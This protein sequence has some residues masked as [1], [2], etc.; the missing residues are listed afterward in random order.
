MAEKW[1]EQQNSRDI[2]SGTLRRIKNSFVNYIY[3][4]LGDIPFS[5]LK[6]KAFIEALKPLQCART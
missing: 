2:T 6:A 1:L 5:Q 4:S 3:P